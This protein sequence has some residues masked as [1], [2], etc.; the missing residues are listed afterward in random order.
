MFKKILEQD[1][2]ERIKDYHDSDPIQRAVLED[3]VDSILEEVDLIIYKYAKANS[4][5]DNMVD[6]LGHLRKEIKSTLVQ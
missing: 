2:L 5:S 3:F 1:H 4:E 6:M